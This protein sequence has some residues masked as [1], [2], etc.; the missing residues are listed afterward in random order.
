MFKASNTFLCVKTLIDY[1]VMYRCWSLFILVPATKDK[2][3]DECISKFDPAIS[4]LGIYPTKMLTA[5]QNDVCV[6]NFTATF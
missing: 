1:K 6:R 2:Y 3:E 5:M 4:L